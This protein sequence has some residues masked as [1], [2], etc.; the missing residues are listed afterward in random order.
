MVTKTDIP[1]LESKSQ[2]IVIPVNCEGISVTGVQK[3]MEQYYP[4]VWE[5][6]K[7][8]CL[9]KVL[10]QGYPYFYEDDKYQFIFFPDKGYYSKNRERYLKMGFKYLKNKYENFGIH[11]I[12][13]YS[14]NKMEQ[15]LINKFY[16]NIS[17]L[18]V[19]CHE[20]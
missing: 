13:F 3:Q 5:H 8:L 6:Y 2:V 16:N 10:R 20:E 11:T 17:D 1:L 15:N 7:L 9:N 19:Y 12:S 14:K 4:E 18:E